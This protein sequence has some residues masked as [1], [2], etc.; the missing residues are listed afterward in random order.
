MSVWG[1]AGARSPDAQSRMHFI[2]QTLVWY[3]V[4]DPFLSVSIAHLHTHFRSNQTINGTRAMELSTGE[5]LG[6]ASAR[7]RSVAVPHGA[8]GIPSTFKKSEARDGRDHT[9]KAG[10]IAGAL[11]SR[12]PASHS[13]GFDRFM[14]VKI[15]V[16]LHDNVFTGVINMTADGA[17]W[18]TG[19]GLGSI[20]GWVL[21]CS[22]ARPRT[23][24]KSI[25]TTIPHT[26]LETSRS[27]PVKPPSSKSGSGDSV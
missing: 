5:E 21:L 15:E 23:H 27:T 7:S 9:C 8:L 2:H 10:R 12:T 4:F 16:R 13:C 18:G 20:F 1:H 22:V 6:V 26:P 25:H 19:V 24:A 11:A 17:V 3:F 14:C